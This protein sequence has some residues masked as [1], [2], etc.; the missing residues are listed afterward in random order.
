MDLA[1]LGVLPLLIV[2]GAIAFG[3]FV[4]GITGL[5][6]PIF[7]IPALALFIPV[8]SA[9]VILALPALVANLWLIVVHREHLPLLRD[10]KAFLIFG[11]IGTLVGTWALAHLDD[12]ILR[13]ILAVWLGVYLLQYAWR[14]GAPQT[15]SSSPHVGGP[16]GFAAG[17][18]QGATGISAPIIA[19]YFHARNLTL[20]A[21]AFAVAFAFA[22]FSVAQLS[23]MA[24]TRLLTPTLLGYSILATITIMIFT[25]VG[26]RF[27]RNLSKQAFEW[28]LLSI[29]LLIEIKLVYDIFS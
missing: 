1:T 18:L 8:E 27:S 9:V 29:F 11:F 7:A 15:I 28:F 3:A 25:P 23:A 21:Y 10:H 16:L 14:K 26:I 12:T 22:L 24:T 13:A 19:P 20:A 17:A 6:L 2:V 5:G 4:K